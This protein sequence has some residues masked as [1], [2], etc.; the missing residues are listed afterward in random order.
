MAA[1][2]PGVVASETRLPVIGVPVSASMGGNDALLSIVQMPPG[3]PV[4]TVGLDRGEN[5]ALLAIQILSLKCT[6]LKAQLLEYRLE[7]E[8]K[9]IASQ[10]SV[11]DC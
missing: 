1:H 2:L 9:V 10:A 4:A 11:N 6:E 5:A 7:M 3:I 8:Q